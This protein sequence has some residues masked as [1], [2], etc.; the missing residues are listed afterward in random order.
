VKKQRIGYFDS[1]DAYG[2]LDPAHDLFAAAL[3]CVDGGTIR[4]QAGQSYTQYVPLHDVDAALSLLPPGHSESAEDPRR[5][6][7]MPL[8]EKGHL[9]PAPLSRNA[10]EKI[11]LSRTTLAGAR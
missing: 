6:S 3:T 7:T 4:S 10:V 9:H 11:T 8:W 1:L 2:S 5:T